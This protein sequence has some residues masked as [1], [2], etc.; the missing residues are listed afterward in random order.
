MTLPILMPKD[1]R[2][3]LGENAERC[4]SRSL[5]MERFA[6]PEA[7]DQERR[8][9][10]ERLRRKQPHRIDRARI[11]VH[12][13]SPPLYA[14]L[15]SRLMVNMAG[16]VMENAGLCLDRFGLPYIP[17]SAVKGCARR[18]ALAA[19]RE[20]CESGAKPGK[21]ESDRYN[22]FKDACEQFEN[23]A[24]MLA[25]IAVVFGW[26]EHDWKNNRDKEGRLISDF[27]W[28]INVEQ[29]SSLSSEQQCNREEGRSSDETSTPSSSFEEAR[30]RLKV[31]RIPNFAGSVSFLPAYPVDL[32]SSG[33]DLPL[34]PPIVGDLEL[35]VVTV[36][37][38]KYYAG[39]E[40]PDNPESVRRWEQEWGTAPDIEDPV[41]NIFPA[42]APGHVFSFALLPLRSG[43]R[44]FDFL[45][46]QAGSSPYDETSVLDWAR[47]WL[48]NGLE[49]FGLGAKTNAGYGWFQNVTE[50]VSE[51][52]SS[53]AEI[54]AIQEKG[55]K[56]DVL[57]DDAKLEFIIELSGKPELCRAWRQE[58]PATAQKVE[59][60][61]NEIES[62]L[63]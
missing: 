60:F 57:S 21:E 8:E 49:V 42:V 52:L 53:R 35:D 59:A 10:F 38:R 51:W 3:V 47:T 61:A 13:S 45:N 1:T 39:P 32:P 20:W 30:R 15:Q 50:P 26:C 19:L 11:S 18:L 16:G 6:R 31:N 43:G 63:P 9:W 48:A 55:E 12:S 37:H 22:L 23:P 4:D 28:A 5:F 46:G 17:G 24:E 41:P 14:Q 36:H 40:R 25:A 2:A 54:Q 33:A 7:K 44:S 62:P 34:S 29:A 27:A 58:N 56:F